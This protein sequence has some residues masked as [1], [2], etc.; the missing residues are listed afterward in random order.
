M[1]LTGATR[2]EIET[3]FSE[4]RKISFCDISVTNNG[5]SQICNRR[6]YREEKSRESNRLRQAVHREKKASNKKVTA[7]S[8]SASPT[9]SP[10][11][12][13]K[14]RL[15]PSDFTLNETL[16][17]YAIS[18]NIDPEKIDDFFEDMKN[19]ADAKSQKYVDWE[20]AFRTRVNNAPEYG[21][22]FLKPHDPWDNI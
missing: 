7:H 14:A 2:Q 16:K 18:K 6:M 20:A 22:H 11:A 4:A 12:Q 8:P 13:T 21:K 10:N 15:W 9:A 5:L 3:F 17:S 19:W 1:K